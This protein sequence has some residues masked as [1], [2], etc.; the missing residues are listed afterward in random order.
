MEA[1]TKCYDQKTACVA[2][3]PSGISRCRKRASRY[4]QCPIHGSHIPR[5]PLLGRPRMSRPGVLGG[6][7]FLLV[8]GPS[9]RAQFL[10][11]AMPSPG[12][13]IAVKTTACCIQLKWNQ[14][15]APAPAKAVR[16]PR[17]R[18]R[19]RAIR[20]RRAR[21]FDVAHT[22]RTRGRRCACTDVESADWHRVSVVFRGSAKNF[23]KIDSARR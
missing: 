4:L 2:N 7:G 17:A 1:L 6:G 14:G 9:R 5:R 16:T 13:E 18:P 21:R 12:R 19:T 15:G 20:G 8:D 10:P 23:C 3:L 11:R 22:V